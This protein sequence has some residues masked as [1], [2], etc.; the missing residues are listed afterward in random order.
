MRLTPSCLQVTV[1][2]LTQGKRKTV[3]K[4]M[5]P[6]NVKSNLPPNHSEAVTMNQ[7][8]DKTNSTNDNVITRLFPSYSEVT[9][10][11]QG[12]CEIV[13]KAVP[14]D[15]VKTNLPSNRRPSPSCNPV[16][17]INP[18][19]HKA[20]GSIVIADSYKTNFPSKC[21]KVNLTS[22][23]DAVSTLSENNEVIRL[24]ENTCSIATTL[25]KSNNF[26]SMTSNTMHVDLCT[27]KSAVQG[28][29]ETTADLQVTPD[30]PSDISED[31][32][33]YDGVVSPTKAAVLNTHPDQHHFLWMTSLCKDR[34]KEQGAQPKMH[35][36]SELPQ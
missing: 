32:S 11:N 26:I 17:T 6:D 16:S 34:W 36:I 21:S 28:K 25:S 15:N 5:L 3:S 20:A 33:F 30:I 27:N 7:D 22:E 12:V 10:L 2:L 24:S 29:G 1:E 9:M 14:P 23:S 8:E 4:V 19:L 35:P 31:D 13:R 18:G